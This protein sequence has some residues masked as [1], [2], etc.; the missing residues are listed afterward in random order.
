MS[1]YTLQQLEAGLKAA[2]D[3]GNVAAATEIA[4]EIR[5]SMQQQ[6]PSLGAPVPFAPGRGS[7]ASSIKEEAKG[8]TPTEQVFGGVG[9]S[10]PL[11][12]QGLTG[13]FGKD[14]KSS[15][16]DWKALRDATPLTSVGGM[17]GDAGLF[18]AL[19]G[20]AILRATNVVGKAPAWMTGRTAA[21]ADTG[22]TG[23]G[24]NYAL[25]PGE[26]QDRILPALT[27]GPL[28]AA[29][30]AIF[31]IG[32][33]INRS[34]SQGGRQ[35]N[36]GEGLLTEAGDRADSLISAL[37]GP[38]PAAPIGVLSSAAAKTQDPTV[39]VLESGARAKRG[40]LWK[41]FDRENAR[42]R[43]DALLSRAGTPEELEGLQG[44]LSGKTGAL[45][46][47]ALAD[48]QLSTIFSK[49]GDV[50]APMLK[51][52]QQKIQDWRFG[53]RPNRDVQSLANYIE[54]ELK[55]GVTP[56]QLYE[57]RKTLTDGIKAGRNDELSNAIKSARV[58]R[59]Q[60]VKLI[61]ETLDT[62][63]GG[64]W[65]EY[66]KTHS[67][68][69]KPIES[70]QALQDIATSLQRGMPPGVVP[71]AM[72]EAAAWKTVG[73]LRDKYGQKELGSKTVD[74]LLP[75]DRELVNLIADSL[76]RQ[77][78]SMT[79]KATLG[80]P[81][82]ALLAN[83]GRAEGVTR[84]VI[85]GGIN[86]VLP[87][88]SVL[89]SKVFDSM[90]RKAEEELSRLLQDPNAL[91]EALVKAMRSRE[92]LELTSRGGAASGAVGSNVLVGK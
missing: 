32:S 72:G 41:P 90:G 65:K 77:A 44:S 4:N 85:D 91:A 75:E 46:E 51:P 28:A 2:A 57:V 26:S 13:L 58:Q 73:N 64:G 83:S 30:P 45:R 61:D 8:R 48:A 66:L 56:E 52:L 86:K 36:V 76:K 29:A 71:P 89:S 5:R 33:A 74:T 42:A 34:V 24:T 31:G 63:S 54:G 39:Q 50:T 79:S 70:K 35:T 20:Q 68:G 60:A 10:M 67:A 84:N 18:G 59:V 43:W 88:G 22:I 69:M 53:L 80:S 78:D 19:P 49:S 27:A 11:A 25:T 55:Q 12:W 81:T 6:N 9:T 17:S 23:I 47:Q 21:V 7:M 87:F 1:G 14:D 38:D 37:R 62:L 15:T 16:Q 40:D 92:I 3:E 82:A